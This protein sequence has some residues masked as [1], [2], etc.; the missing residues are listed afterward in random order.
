MTLLDLQKQ[1]T[2]AA[3][4]PQWASLISLFCKETK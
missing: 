1:E 4:S 3:V 2:Q